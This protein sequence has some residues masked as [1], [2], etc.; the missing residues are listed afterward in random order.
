MPSSFL[1][2]KKPNIK[3][4]LTWDKDIVCFPKNYSKSNAEIPIPRGEEELLILSCM[5]MAL[6]IFVWFPR[7]GKTRVSL[8]KKGLIGKIHLAES[9]D[10]ERAKDKI[11]SVF[12]KAM[13]GNRD[14]PFFILHP[15]GGGSRSLTV[16][17][18]STSFVWTAKEVAK[19]AGKGSIYIWAQDDLDV[20]DTDVIIVESDDDSVSDLQYVLW[21]D[22]ASVSR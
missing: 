1:K 9:M 15:I 10:E 3:S 7:L 4:E 16:P 21:V 5:G 19:V 12:S 2:K 22:C 14:F 11:C 8:A 20:E 17:R 13:K 18:T 6:I